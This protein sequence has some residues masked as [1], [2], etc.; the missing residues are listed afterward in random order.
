MNPR[1]VVALEVGAREG[2][3]A[4]TAGPGQAQ[5]GFQGQA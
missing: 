3:G 2:A 4:H 5:A 1:S